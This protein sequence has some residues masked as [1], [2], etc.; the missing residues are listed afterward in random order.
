MAPLNAS[1]TAIVWLEPNYSAK[2]RDADG[3]WV[4]KSTG[5][6]DRDSARR[7]AAQWESAAK[8]RQ[9]RV[10]DPRAERIAEHAQRSIDT[11][12]SD[13]IAHLATKHG[14]LAHRERTEKYIREFIDAG[15]WQT[16]GDIDADDVNRH[17]AAVKEKGLAAR[18]I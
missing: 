15:Q 5:T 8:L 11:H 12:L 4:R 10:I 18:S 17:A 2:Y 7:I 1:G 16:I 13:Y 3:K 9:E 14:T 6:R